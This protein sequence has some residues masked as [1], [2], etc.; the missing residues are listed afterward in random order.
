[1][2][3]PDDRAA[4]DPAPDAAA[5]GTDM[6]RVEVTVPLAVDRAFA[7]F[8]EGLAGW[9][10]NRVLQDPAATTDPELTASAMTLDPVVGGVWSERSTDGTERIW[11]AVRAWEP[12]RALTLDWAV[13]GDR[14]PEPDG[15]ASTVVVRFAEVEGALTTVIVE[16]RDLDAHG[17]G[18]PAVRRWVAGDDGW[19]AILQAYVSAARG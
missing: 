1:M 5:P 16:H 7:L 2:S 17:A 13:G 15:R 3:A 18:E 4:G 8:T 6:V 14:T 10:P 19:W 9:W 12:P 11:G